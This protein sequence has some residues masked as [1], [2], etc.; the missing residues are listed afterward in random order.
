M[1]KVLGGS[2]VGN[3]GMIVLMYPKTPRPGL[4]TEISSTLSPEDV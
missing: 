1:Q 3:S 2:A 4:V